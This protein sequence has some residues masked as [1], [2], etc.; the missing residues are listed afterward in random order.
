MRLF[1]SLCAVCGFISVMMT[2]I[3]VAGFD[4]L[5]AGS[6]ITVSALWLINSRFGMMLSA[7]AAVVI[8]C[9]S[10][11]NTCAMNLRQVTLSSRLVCNSF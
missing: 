6:G 10:D 11:A 9:A 7:L 2:L 5:D 3:L 1:I 4:F 8:L